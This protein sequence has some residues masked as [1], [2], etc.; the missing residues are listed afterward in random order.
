MNTVVRPVRGGQRRCICNLIRG[1]PLFSRLYGDCMVILKV[2]HLLELAEELLPR[3]LHLSQRLRAQEVLPAVIALAAATAAILAL[4]L[5]L[6]FLLSFAFALH[7]FR[8]LANRGT[9]AGGMPV[10]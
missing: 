7:P 1:W 4:A 10:F 6:A 2:S 3:P 9:R 8:A 5:A